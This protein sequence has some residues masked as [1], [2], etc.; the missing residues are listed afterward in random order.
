MWT[1]FRIALYPVKSLD[2]V[3]VEQAE[4]L[5]GGGLAWDRQY[6]LFDADGKVIN[7]KK[8]ATIQQIR[9]RFDLAGQTITVSAPDHDLA[10]EQFVLSEN[11][12]GLE[13]W[14]SDYFDQRVTLKSNTST[15]FPDDLEAS[16]PTIIST[17]TYEELAR[18][19][20]GISVDEL[21]LR[22]RANLEFAGDLPFCEDRLYNP[23]DPPVLFR[24]GAVTFAGSNPCKRCVVP[25]R[26]PTTG[27]TDAQF[28]KTF[29]RKRE[30]TFPSWGVLSLFRNMYRLAV[31][32]RLHELPE[33]QPPRIQCGDTLEILSR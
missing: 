32:T 2:P 3:F 4:V 31:N 10:A 8:Q 1:L 23:L 14:F 5:P 16:G 12:P 21:R 18:W 19:F 11:Q 25:S 30:E 33:G 7:A 26:V 29:I 27:Q 28:M 9:A 24:A 13:A 17:Q 22:F 15:G 6:A 20:P